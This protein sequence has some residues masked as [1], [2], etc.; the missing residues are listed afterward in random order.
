MS[1][2]CLTMGT[3]GSDVY[4]P[5][6]PIEVF[7]GAAQLG[8]VGAVFVSP[9]GNWIQLGDFTAKHLPDILA[10]GIARLIIAEVVHF[11]ASRYESVNAIEIILS[12][13][14]EGFDGRQAYLAQARSEMLG[15]IGARDIKVTPQHH[16]DHQAHF[17]VSGVWTYD[18]PSLVALEAVL[19]AERAAY[20]QR[21]AQVKAPGRVRSLLGRVFATDGAAV[22]ALKR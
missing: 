5:G 1:F 18:R 2:E 17:A 15:S 8:T 3:A 14:I 7:D 12:R 19:S 22:G 16:P 21:R 20:A 4:V 9:T 6:T 11:V 10:K 13:D